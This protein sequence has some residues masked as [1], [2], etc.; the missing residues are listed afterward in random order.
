MTRS[1]FIDSFSVELFALFVFK[2]YQ[3][4]RKDS[5]QMAYVDFFVVV[6]VIRMTSL[7]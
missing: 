7:A 6:V 3:K 4:Y 2:K 1:D 5:V